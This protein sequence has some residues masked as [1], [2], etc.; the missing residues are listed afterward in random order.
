MLQLLASELVFSEGEELNLLALSCG[1]DSVGIAGDHG[2]DGGGGVDGVDGGEAGQ[3]VRG[4]ES[5]EAGWKW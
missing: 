2:C 1:N 5:A 3:R 4:E